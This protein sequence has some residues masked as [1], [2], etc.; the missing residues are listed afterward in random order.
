MP[1][2]TSQQFFHLSVTSRYNGIA[3]I[4]TTYVDFNA[5]GTKAWVLNVIRDAICDDNI[6]TIRPKRKTRIY[7]RP[8][9]PTLTNKDKKR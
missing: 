2:E 3:I 9:D 1:K 4:P 6:V 8:I 5:E 7:P